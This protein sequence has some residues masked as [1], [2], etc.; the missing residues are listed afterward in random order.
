MVQDKQALDFFN[1]IFE[2]VTRLRQFDTLVM[3]TSD[4]WY[5]LAEALLDLQIMHLDL[6]PTP[7]DDDRTVDPEHL[8]D[9]L[10]QVLPG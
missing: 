4:K 3:I 8:R 7:I 5:N 10:K 2:L 6:G 9:T 1:T